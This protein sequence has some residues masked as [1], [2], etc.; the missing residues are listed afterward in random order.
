MSREGLSPK[1]NYPA[2]RSYTDAHHDLYFSSDSL[3]E[4]K[5]DSPGQ[6]PG[7]SESGEVAL[8]GRN[9]RCGRPFRACTRWI[10]NPGLRPGLSTVAS[11]RL[12]AESKE[13][14][15]QQYTNPHSRMD[16]HSGNPHPSAAPFSAMNWHA[17]PVA[18]GIALILPFFPSTWREVFEMTSFPKHC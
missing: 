12:C 10:G 1:T 8:K 2:T 17:S 13:L 3:E 14:D 15:A 18:S 16:N 4:A 11:S 7:S 9:L 6:R 5:V